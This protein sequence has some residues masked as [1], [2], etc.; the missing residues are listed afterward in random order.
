[1]RI[2]RHLRALTVGALAGLFVVPPQPVKA[3]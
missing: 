3:Q 2:T 1:M